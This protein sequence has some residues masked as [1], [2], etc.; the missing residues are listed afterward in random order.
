MFEEKELASVRQQEEALASTFFHE[1][2]KDIQSLRQR[3]D[4]LSTEQ[5]ER[6]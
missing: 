4:H 2:M 5:R 1:L 6:N 3:T